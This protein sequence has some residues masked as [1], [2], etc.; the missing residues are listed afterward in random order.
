MKHFEINYDFMPFQGVMYFELKCQKQITLVY[1]FP[2]TFF[3][4]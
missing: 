4:H 2:L 3:S 1:T